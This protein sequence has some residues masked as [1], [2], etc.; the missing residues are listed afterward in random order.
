ML[1]V[2]VSH[3]LSIVGFLLISILFFSP[4]ILEGKKIYQNDIIQYN[5][6]VKEIADFR[7]EYNKEPLWTNSMF[8]GMPAYLISTL[9]SG[10]KISNL[11]KIF[12]ATG[13][14]PVSYIFIYLLGFYIALLLFRVKPW[15]AF[16]GAIAY[17]FSS[18]FFAIISA[19]HIAKVWALGYMPP[20]IAGVYTAFRGK[21]LLG[22]AVTGLFLALQ[23]LINHLQITYYTLLIIVIYGIFE[24]VAAIRNKQVVEL[25]KPLLLLV[26]AAGLAVSSH[27]AALWTTYEYGKYSI[28]GPS[29]LTANTENQ[30][31]GLDKD[32]A[33]Q[34]SVGIDE[35]LSL[36]VPNIK[37]APSAFGTK[38]KSYDLLK[39]SEGGTAY[40]KQ[41]L[42]RLPSYWGDQ[43]HTIPV[44]AGAVVCFLFV[45]GLFVIKGRL[46]W[47]LF[48]ITVISI[49]L[50][51]GRH[52]PLLTNFMLDHFPGYNKFRSVSMT[53]IIAEFAMPLLGMLA[54]REIINGDFD[55]KELI[56]YLKYPLYILGGITLFLILFPGVFGLSAASDE[57]MVNQGQGVLVDAFIHDRKNLVRADAFRSLVFILL[58]A[59]L[60]YLF[61][62]KKLK[63]NYLVGSLAILFLIDLWPV[64]KRYLNSDN[65][66][67]K[68][69]NNAVFTPSTADLIILKDK[70]PGYRVLNLTVSPF[71]DATTSYFH[72]SVGG[73]HGAKMRRY[74]E[75]IDYSIIDELNRLISTLRGNATPQAVDSTMAGLNALNILNTRYIIYNPEAPPLVNK[76]EPGAA[77]F[78]DN[79]KI[80]ADAD[81]E[82][83]SVASFNPLKEVLIDKRYESMLE[84]Y[85]PQ[86][87]TVANINLANYLPNHLTYK[88]KNTTEQIA[89]FSEIFYD[90]GWEAYIDGSPATYF[91]TNYL[92]RAMRVPAGEHTIDFKFHPKSYYTGEKISLAGSLILILLV[93]GSLYYEI[94]KDNSVT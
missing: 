63:V 26:V 34:W 91:R 84:G 79:Y 70:E 55:K 81:E 51:W 30:T 15:L 19:G 13:F 59:G 23:L 52:F 2:F 14:R 64:D 9:Y 68:K 7:I 45:F 88:A 38:S 75:L 94:K 31:S 16:A 1:N 35:S 12:T 25:Y 28:R 77:W 11:H 22:S 58:V 78:V 6:S 42:P 53:L 20:I 71:Q 85:T 3:F 29:E 87:D 4:D 5:G 74:Q 69:E 47:W 54:I 17:G 40:A 48:T 44:Y 33:T 39:R 92:L 65:F 8:G 56:K 24:L 83:Q 86:K 32:Y 61:I 49:M 60:I 43:P 37:G 10:N 21:M 57:Q 41:M 80:V 27:I 46:K 90:K 89:V 72:H 67:T 50:S 66:M 93:L 76:H 73:Y 62:N 18:Y 82:I 36:L